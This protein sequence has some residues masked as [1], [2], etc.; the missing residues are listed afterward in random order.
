MQGAAAFARARSVVITLEDARAATHLVASLRSF[1]PHLPIQVAAPDLPTQDRMRA[2]GAANVI[3]TSVEGNIQLG[4]EMLRAAGVAEPAIDML[5][6]TLR[7]SDYALV[8]SARQ[9]RH[10]PG[11][12]LGGMT[13]SEAGGR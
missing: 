5:V 8:R 13:V 7:K 10:D 1:Y 4:Q 3:C 11:D 2:L 6:E 12:R 9:S